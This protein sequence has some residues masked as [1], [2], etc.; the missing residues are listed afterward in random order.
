MPQLLH[1]AKGSPQTRIYEPG[2]NNF[3][4][5]SISGAST[6]SVAFIFRVFPKEVAEGMIQ[7]VLRE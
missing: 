4:T 6:K 2:R 3:R 5:S 7:E 1:N